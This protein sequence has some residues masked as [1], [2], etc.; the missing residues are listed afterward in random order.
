MAALTRYCL[1]ASREGA[2]TTVAGRPFQG[3]SVATKNDCWYA[4]IR[5]RSP[6]YPLAK[7]SEVQWVRA[8][9]VYCV[10]GMSTR[11]FCIWYIILSLAMNMF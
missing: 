5:D 9:D 7:C 3:A 8:G 2:V 6:L 1:K 4:R 11:P 10:A